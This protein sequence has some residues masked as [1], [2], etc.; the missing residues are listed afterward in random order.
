MVKN[1]QKRYKSQNTPHEDDFDKFGDVPRYLYNAKKQSGM[2]ILFVVLMFTPAVLIPWV[3]DHVYMNNIQNGDDRVK[4]FEEYRKERNAR[5]AAKRAGRAPNQHD[6]EEV[7]AHSPR[8]DNK[9]DNKAKATPTAVHYKYVL[10]GGG[11]ASYSAYKAIRKNDPNADVLIVTEEKYAPYQRP[12]LSKELWKTKDPNVAQNLTFTDWSGK[13]ASVFYEDEKSYNNKSTK[14]IKGATVSDLDVNNQRIT[15]SD[16]RVFEY[17]KCLL[18]TGGSPRE[19]IGSEK[20]P[21]RIT[22]FR[23]LDDFKRLDEMSRKNATIVIVGGSFLGTELAYALAQ[24][25][26]SKVVQVF[27]EPEVLARNLPRYLSKRIRKVLQASGVKLKPNLNVVGVEEKSDRVVVKMDNG[28]ALEAD[29][30][31]TATGIYPNTDLAEKAGLEID[32]V[33]GGVVTNSELEAR[34]N[35]FVAGDVLSYYD[36][37]LGRRR[38]EHYEHAASTGRHAGQNMS[39][40]DGAKKPYKHISMFWSDVGPVNF[41]AVGEINSSL[42]TY[43]VWDG[44]SITQPGTNWS[45]APA[46]YKNSQFHKGVVYYLRDRKVV[47]ILLWNL[48]GKI[49]EARN[50]IS[51]KQIYENLHDLR[52]QIKT[53]T[54]PAK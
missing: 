32:P 16:G 39:V 27:L 31:I 34:N 37:L 5:L 54:P 11:T 25:G 14:L 1:M 2:G 24:K 13:E 36:T 7:V 52:D 46:P 45:S 23:N 50:V 9:P 19:I 26:G 51:K 40:G 41:E 47:G 33:N 29:Y 48:P 4:E 21:G 6:E 44:V 12:P 10:I 30:V 49:N 53:S 15:L 28:E 17:D 38:S 8:K 42:N 3:L 18:A 43:A 35:V 22:T 20:I